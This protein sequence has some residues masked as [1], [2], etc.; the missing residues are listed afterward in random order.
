MTTEPS[1]PTEAEIFDHARA[2]GDAYAASY[3]DS[4]PRGWHA[5]DPNARDDFWDSAA[6]DLGVPD[7]H[8][9]RAM[10]DAYA[11]PVEACPPAAVQ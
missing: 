10:P 9:L 5:W 8:P 4:P 1:L 6:L 11:G 7:G 3:G 2:I